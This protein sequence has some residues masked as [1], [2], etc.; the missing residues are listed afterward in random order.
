[1]WS[2]H[3]ECIWTFIRGSPV[4]VRLNETFS[5]QTG[6]KGLNHSRVN[7]TRHDLGHRIFIH[8]GGCIVAIESCGHLDD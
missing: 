6:Q 3:G 1:M 5:L 2:E 4:W 8:S 7:E